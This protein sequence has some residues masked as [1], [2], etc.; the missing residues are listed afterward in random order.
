M[1]EIITS[2]LDTDLYKFSMQQAVFHQYPNSR[3]LY[4][5]ICRNKGVK[6]GFLVEAIKQELANL[7]YVR[8][9]KTEYEY[10]N[11][12]SFFSK[13]YVK[14]LKSFKFNAKYVSVASNAD[15]ELLMT[16]NGPWVDTILFE[17]PLLAIVNEL[18]FRATTDYRSLNGRGIAN[19][20][21]KINM[22]N[23]HPC[24]SISEFGTRRR[25]SKEWQAF[26]LKE[27]VKFC[28]AQVVGTSNVKLA[29][30]N[31][32][33]PIGTMAH[34]FCSA[35]LSL[36]DDISIAQKRMLYCWLQEYGTNLGIALSDT[37][38]SDAFFRD[39]DEVLSKQFSGVR[40]D[41][42]DPIQFGWKTIAHYNKMG[43]DPRTKTIVFSDGLDVPKAIEIF[44]T[45]TGKIGL[46][47]GIGTN[48]S[49]DLGATALNIVIKLIACNGKPVVKIS[50]EPKK[51]IGNDDMIRRVKEVYGL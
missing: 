28:P 30:L 1:T 9:N 49:N 12:I 32:I 2:M 3:V 23:Q 11:T 36:V 39:F 5:F 27:L 29:M 37:F 44:E 21:D 7:E 16:I 24:I 51:A 34:E 46:S 41:S 33:K 42:G 35:H 47:F 4:Q 26:V 15:G 50:D 40:H 18:Y 8:L 25:Y 17:V 13:D 10:L 19:L 45:F 22:I 48:L 31:G 38:T 20:K 43:I 6:L 14:Y